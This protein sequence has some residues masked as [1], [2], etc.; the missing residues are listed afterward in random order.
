MTVPTAGTSL[1]AAAKALMMA[2]IIR[3]LGG[4]RIQMDEKKKIIGHSKKEM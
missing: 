2:S 1:S 4:V 3:G